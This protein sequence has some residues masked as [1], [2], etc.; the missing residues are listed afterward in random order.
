MSKQNAMDDP[1]RLE[2]DDSARSVSNVDPDIVDRLYAQSRRY[3]STKRAHDE[4]DIEEEPHPQEPQ[5]AKKIKVY[6]QTTIA[7]TMRVKPKPKSNMILECENMPRGANGQ[8]DEEQCYDLVEGCFNAH[9]HQH[10]GMRIPKAGSVF[11]DAKP[12]TRDQSAHAYPGDIF[13]AKTHGTL[14]CGIKSEHDGKVLEAVAARVCNK[15]TAEMGCKG[16]NKQCS[17]D[18]MTV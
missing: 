15:H 10:S 5:A 12:R 13:D 11:A 14:V 1:F 6:R 9:R 8:L 3:F 18:A 17:T 2:L 4:F 16:L 7:D